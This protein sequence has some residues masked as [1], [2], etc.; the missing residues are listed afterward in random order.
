MRSLMTHKYHF[1]CS[2]LSR[3][4]SPAA[5]PPQLLHRRAIKWV[6]APMQPT[7][8]H[9]ISHHSS[10]SFPTAEKKERRIEKHILEKQ[11][12]VVE[13]I[14]RLSLFPLFSMAESSWHALEIM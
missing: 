8:S 12:L 14:G 5:L 4:R 6:F 1:N 11:E 3:L 7:S 9:T 10:A 13:L 2:F